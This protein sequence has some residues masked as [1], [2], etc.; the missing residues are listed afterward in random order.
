[1][2]TDCRP[3]LPVPRSS[4]QSPNDL[5]GC[6]QRTAAQLGRLD[7]VGDVAESRARESAWTAAEFIFDFEHPVAWLIGLVVVG[8]ALVATG[9]RSRGGPAD[10]REPLDSER[11]MQ[12]MREF[13]VGRPV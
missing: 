5:G 6:R 1:M 4:S 9:R 12:K 7:T 13:A 3:P 11:E 10:R 8:V 2:P